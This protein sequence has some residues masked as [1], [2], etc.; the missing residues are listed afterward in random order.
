MYGVITDDHR[1]LSSLTDLCA[2][3]INVLY[4]AIHH[5]RVSIITNAAAVQCYRLENVIQHWN[6][7]KISFE[8]TFCLWHLTSSDLM[9]R[10]NQKCGLSDCSS[11]L[12]FDG[13]DI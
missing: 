8:I 11:V 2:D 3:S 13:I 6:F 5:R 12:F 1:A 10:T 4:D 7:G 9:E